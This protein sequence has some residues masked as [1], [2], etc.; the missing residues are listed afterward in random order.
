MSV[1]KLFSGYFSSYIGLQKIASVA[2]AI[3]DSLGQESGVGRKLAHAT[4]P[5]RDLRG[6]CRVAF[7]G[8]NSYIFESDAPV[9][10]GV[11]LGQAGPKVL[12]F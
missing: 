1:P 7:I 8:W 2:I 9:E 5:I 3:R 6:L 11:L 12:D 4:A 10:S